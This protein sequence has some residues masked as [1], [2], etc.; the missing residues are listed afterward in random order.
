MAIIKV[1]ERGRYILGTQVTKFEEDFANYLGIKH[2]VSVASGTDALA[3]GLRAV[4]VRKN[5]EVITVDY[6][7]QPTKNAIE[8]LNATPVLIGVNDSYTMDVTKIQNA[9]TSNTKAIVPVHLYGLPAWMSS[10]MGTA[11]FENIPVVEDCAQSH[12]ARIGTKKTGTIGKVGCFSFYPTKNL[13][14]FGD[15]GAVVTD[16]DTIAADLRNMRESRWTSRLDEL[17]AAVLRVKLRKLDEGNLRRRAIAKRYNNG[18]QDTSLILPTEVG[19]RKHIYHQYVIRTSYQTELQ[20]ALQNRGVQTL[21]RY[22]VT[23]FGGNVLSLPMYPEL[24]DTQIDYIITS[25]KESL[26]VI[27]A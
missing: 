15:G 26:S 18:L 3:M 22:P 7:A 2:V 9:I 1:I 5:D 24:N 21:I 27:E 19:S 23:P 6:T 12:G 10:I 16:D 25:I 17:Q 20:E 14:C 13:G 11:N 4:G 8:L